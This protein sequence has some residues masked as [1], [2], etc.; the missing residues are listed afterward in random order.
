VR[1][2]VYKAYNDLR[3][4]ITRGYLGIAWWFIEPVLYMATFYFAFAV[5]FRRGEGDYVSFLLCGLVFWKWFAGS[6]SLG[7]A[8]LTS[9]RGIMRQVYIPKYIFPLV[10]VLTVTAKFFMVFIV[11]LVYLLSVGYGPHV[12]WL[13]LAPIFF[14]QFLLALGV[15]GIL[16][17]LVPFFPEIRGLAENGLMLLFFLSGIFFDISSISREN[18]DLLYLNPMAGLID[19][20]RDILIHGQIDFSVLVYPA[21]ISVLLVVCGYLLLNHFD[22]QYPKVIMS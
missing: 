11:L 16:A 3:A 2:A 21:C 14:I 20:Y 9:N 17:S 8:S 5:M 18:A 1:L 15:A 22:R 6:I 19:Q 7:C 13:L 4:E 10:S 12:T